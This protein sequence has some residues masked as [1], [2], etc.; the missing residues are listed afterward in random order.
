MRLLKYEKPAGITHAQWGAP[1]EQDSQDNSRHSLVLNLA[2]AGLSNAQIADEVGYS[3]SRVGQILLTPENKET[4]RKMQERF[5]GQ[6]AADRIKSLV[7]KALDNVEHILESPQ[8]KSNLKLDASKYILD[9]HLG[10][11]MQKMEVK[12]N[13]F[14]SLLEQVEQLQRQGTLEQVIDVTPRDEIDDFL[15]NEIQG[16]T[17]GVRNREEKTDEYVSADYETAGEQGEEC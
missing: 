4:V 14:S 17:I 9:H 16:L 13:L 1:T 3:V 6:S 11:A 12:G 5:F 8:E 2:A 10:K 15:D 7:G